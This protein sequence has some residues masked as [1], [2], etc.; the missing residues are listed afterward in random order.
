MTLGEHVIGLKGSAIRTPS[1]GFHWCWL[2]PCHRRFARLQLKEEN[3]T[4]DPG[5]RGW[6]L[7]LTPKLQL[8]PNCKM[9][10]A[11]V[12]TAYLIIGIAHFSW[13]GCQDNWSTLP[14]PRGTKI[15]FSLW[16]CRGEDNLKPIKTKTKYRPRFF[17][18]HP[19]PKIGIDPLWSIPFFLHCC[20]SRES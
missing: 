1:S 7:N 14:C 11:W 8:H 3:L 12:L 19:S 10:F 9:S 2:V 16:K 15:S 13:Q 17:G 4:S 5:W 18:P 20:L 6:H